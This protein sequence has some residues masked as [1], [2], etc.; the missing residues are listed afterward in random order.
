M[1]MSVIY[2]P[3]LFCVDVLSMKLECYFKS[4]EVGLWID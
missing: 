4:N 3:F 1:V 2:F